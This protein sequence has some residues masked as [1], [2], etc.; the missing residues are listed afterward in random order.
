MVKEKRG[1]YWMQSIWNT[2][3]F[4]SLFCSFS[5]YFAVLA[6][7]TV[8]MESH[9]DLDSDCKIGDSSQTSLGEASQEFW[10]WILSLVHSLPSLL[11]KL[12]QTV[13]D[14]PSPSLLS[15]TGLIP[16]PGCCQGM[17]LWD[18]HSTPQFVYDFW[19]LQPKGHICQMGW[20][21]KP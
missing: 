18:D 12:Y 9:A 19:M 17:R 8:T 10:T 3:A 20:K 5:L 1:V 15:C 2:A 14:Y 6:S 7:C 13:W 21:S 11:A 4:V 16:P